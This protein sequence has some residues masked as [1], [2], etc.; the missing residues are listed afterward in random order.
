MNLVNY[1]YQRKLARL[2]IARPLTQAYA[3][4]LGLGQVLGLEVGCMGYWMA[5]TMLMM[6][7]IGS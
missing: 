3:I 7:D 6:V 2:M 4:M 1:T 5:R